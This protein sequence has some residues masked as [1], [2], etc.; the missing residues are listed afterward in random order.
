[1]SKQ[2]VYISDFFVD[3]VLGGAELND[4]ELLNVLKR[5]Y[6]VIKI[7]SH[8]VD[9]NYN[10]VNIFPTPIHILDMK[11]FDKI[12]NELIDYAY[13]LKKKEPKGKFSS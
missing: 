10:T 5:R 1:M 2:V 3:Q 6:E 11:G 4:Q 7:N 9:L 12:Q 8:L 13:G